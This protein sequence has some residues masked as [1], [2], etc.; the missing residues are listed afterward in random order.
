MSC[1]SPAPRTS[2]VTDHLVVVLKIALGLHCEQPTGHGASGSIR[3]IPP[4]TVRGTIMLET[5]PAGLMIN[6]VDTAPQTGRRA[7]A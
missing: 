1:S 7:A 5:H 4:R 3:R 2:E 6:V